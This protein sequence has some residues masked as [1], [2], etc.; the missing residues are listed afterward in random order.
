MAARGHLGEVD[1]TE[2]LRQ[3]A[4]MQL[5]PT[6]L[7]SVQRPIT[8]PHED[9]HHGL[10]HDDLDGSG[11][12]VRLQIQAWTTTTVISVLMVG[13][14]DVIGRRFNRRQPHGRR[15]FRAPF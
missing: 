13:N 6:P 3:P 2:L 12:I 4:L 7:F 14:Y 8:R 10:I 15:T 9:Q 5:R 11:Q 1:L